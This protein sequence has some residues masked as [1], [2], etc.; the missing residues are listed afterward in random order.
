M[1]RRQYRA[2][3]QQLLFD[4]ESA[5]NRCQ[6]NEYYIAW[7]RLDLLRAYMLRAGCY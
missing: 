3:R 6:L 1:T 4:R 5:W 2:H 7:A